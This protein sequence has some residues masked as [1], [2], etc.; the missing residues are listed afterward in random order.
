MR[1]CPEY[2]K[3]AE[4]VSRLSELIEREAS[5]AAATPER[6]KRTQL[7]QNS[8]LSAIKRLDEHTITCPHCRS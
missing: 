2:W 4:D 5:S 7:L 6:A 3:L 1:H 8:Y